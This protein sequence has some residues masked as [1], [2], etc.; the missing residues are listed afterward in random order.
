MLIIG[1]GT[2]RPVVEERVT[3]VTEVAPPTPT[4][5]PTIAPTKTLEEVTQIVEHEEII[6]TIK[7]RFE[8]AEPSIEADFERKR[9]VYSE[10]N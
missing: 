5:M 6:P 4:P 2:P 10:K 8:E 7:P 3:P 1:D 9:T